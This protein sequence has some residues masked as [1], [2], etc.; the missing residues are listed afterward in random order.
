MSDKDAVTAVDDALAAVNTTFTAVDD[1]YCVAEYH[2]L[3]ELRSDD[4]AAAYAAAI[5]D[6]RAAN[7]AYL[8][9]KYLTF[10]WENNHDS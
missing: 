8:A 10:E 5:L 9:A 6:A 2:K 7:A 4:T 3:D 1:A